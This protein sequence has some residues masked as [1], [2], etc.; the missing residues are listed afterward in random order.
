VHWAPVKADQTVDVD[1]MRA[2]I[3]SNT[4][5]LVGSAPT[6]PHG[7]IDDIPAIAA[8]AKVCVWVCV[9][10]CVCVCVF[11]CV[12]CVCVCFIKNM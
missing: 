11:V 9:C 8:L 3:N 4:I 10:V 6:Y 12:V 2:L 1:A 5:M 7:M